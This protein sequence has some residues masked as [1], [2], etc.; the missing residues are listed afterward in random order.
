MIKVEF[1]QKSK[2]EILIF[3]IDVAGNRK[4][5]GRIFAPAG[6]GETHINAIQ[7]C[8]FDHAFDFWGCGVYGDKATGQ[9]KKDIQ[10]MWFNNYDK[11]DNK[12]MRRVKIGEKEYTRECGAKYTQDITKDRFSIAEKDGTCGKCFNHPCTCEVNIIYENPYTVK[13]SQDLMLY[14]K[15][16]FDEAVKNAVINSLEN[17]S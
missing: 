16:D 8:G 7:I 5:I 14:T 4:E 15:K 1:E 11:M 2:K 12:E 17:K 13:R 3:G 10:L 6:S 9:M